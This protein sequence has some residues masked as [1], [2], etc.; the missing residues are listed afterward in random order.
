MCGPSHEYPKRPVEGGI[1]FRTFLLRIRVCIESL[2]PL[3]R[4]GNNQFL[5]SPASGTSVC[6]P[7]YSV[8]P[9]LTTSPTAGTGST[10][11]SG[12]K[13]NLGFHNCLILLQY[14]FGGTVYNGRSFEVLIATVLCKPLKQR[15]YVLVSRNYLR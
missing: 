10:R 9:I 1:S 11:S 12:S 6:L 5:A 15:R 2:T 14:F 7:L 8:P 3:Y 13:T 4:S